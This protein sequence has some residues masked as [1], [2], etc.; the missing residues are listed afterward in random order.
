[1]VCFG[2]IFR[3]IVSKEGKTFDVKII[4]AL[5]KMHVPTTLQEIQGLN[6]MAQFYI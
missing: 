4:E 5:A 6:G 2:T 1:M 3:F